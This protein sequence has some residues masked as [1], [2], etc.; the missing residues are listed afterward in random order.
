LSEVEYPN[1]LLIAILGIKM[2]ITALFHPSFLKRVVIILPSSYPLL[3][4]PITLGIR[5]LFCLDKD[6][7][8]YEG[9]LPCKSNL[10]SLL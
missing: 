3:L 7:N 9:E 8:N 6:I 2:K 1:S 5:H 10:Q 4:S